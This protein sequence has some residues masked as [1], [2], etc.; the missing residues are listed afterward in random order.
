[1]NKHKFFEDKSFTRTN[2]QGHVVVKR[3]F[4]MCCH[5]VKFTFA[6]IDDSDEVAYGFYFMDRTTQYWEEKECIRNFKEA[7]T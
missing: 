1:M 7:Y 6:Y 5:V 2:W 4:C 3:E